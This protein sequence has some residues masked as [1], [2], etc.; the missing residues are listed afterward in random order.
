MKGKKTTLIAVPCTII[1]TLALLVVAPTVVA[2][3]QVMDFYDKN[4]Y[5]P[6][7][8][9]GLPINETMDRCIADDYP[10]G[11]GKWC[12]SFTMRVTAERLKGN[13]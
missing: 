5:Q 12:L 13:I 10:K 4:G 9:K 11:D 3:Y 7:W 1:A 8:A 6:D 2:H